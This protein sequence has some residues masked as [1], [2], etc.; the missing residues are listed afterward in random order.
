MRRRL[1]AAAC[2]AVT[3]LGA[4]AA[5]AATTGTYEGWLYK[6]SGE[7][8]RG[9]MTTLTVTDEADGEQGFRLSVYNM[10]LGCPYLDKYG[11]PARARFRFVHT[12]VVEDTRIDDTREFPSEDEP[13]HLV[14]LRGRFSGRGFRGR[15]TVRSAPGVSGAC[16]GAARVRVRR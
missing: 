7:R 4:S 8:W 15:V 9:T 1:I 14:R 13:T 6:K 16:V 2:A 10:R 5:F 3:L 12:G 11:N